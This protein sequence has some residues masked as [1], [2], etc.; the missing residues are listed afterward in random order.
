MSRSIL[1][2]A[3][4]ALLTACCA[5]GPLQAAGCKTG[6]SALGSA[7][8][9]MNYDPPKRYNMEALAKTRAIAAW[10][11][12]VRKSCPG[13]LSYWWAASKR[14]V[15]CEGHAGGLSCEVTAVPAR[16]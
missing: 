3:M 4:I 14:S 10:R 16:F 8:N 11:A 7:A 15:I 6:V 5:A 13:H 1:T 2:P 9:P 12:E